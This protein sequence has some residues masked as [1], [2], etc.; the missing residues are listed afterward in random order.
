MCGINGVIY[1]NQKSNLSEINNMNNAIKHRGPDDDGLFA[2]E[3]I[4]L[5]HVRL[6]ILDL[7]K[8]GK[9]PMTYDNRFWISY[10]GEVY[11][12][13]EIRNNLIE[14]GYKFFSETDTEVILKSYIEWG[15][16]CFEKFNGMWALAILDIIKKKLIISRDR[17]GVKPCYY[18]LNKNKFIFS[19][20]IK[21]ILSSFSEI[22]LDKDKLLL[23]VR[24]LEKHFTTY[25]E[26]INILPPGNIL[27]IDITNLNISKLR[28]WRSI[29]NLSTIELNYNKSKEK[30]KSLLYEATKLRLVSDTKISTSL[31]GGIDSAVIFAILNSYSQKNNLSLDP[32][33]NK[34]NN[35]TFENAVELSKFYNRK[36]VI[37]N[38][39][40][41]DTEDFANLFASLEQPTNYFNQINIYKNQKENGFKISIDGHGADEC[42]G[43]YANNIL[44]FIFQHHNSLADAYKAY[45]SIKGEDNL[46]KLGKKYKF[47]SKV[48]KYNG[49]NYA[50]DYYKNISINQ[51]LLEFIEQNKKIEVPDFFLEDLNDLNELNYDQQSLLVDANY[52]NLQWLLNKWDRASMSNSVEIRSP[53]L[54]WNFFQYAISLPNSFKIKNGK[55]KSILRDAFSNILSPS[56]NNDFRKQGLIPI[57]MPFDHQYINHLEKILNQESFVKSNLWN[58]KK[59]KSKFETVKNNNDLESLRSLDLL[60]K[61][62]LMDIGFKNIKKNN[63]QNKTKIVNNYNFLNS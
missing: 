45:V 62:Y 60:S 8:K 17:Y 26:D 50:K 7:S 19:S 43:G 39:T 29:D 32:F 30:I 15:D 13:K 37:I 2:F 54:D 49:I 38:E 22:K 59:I 10:N 53:Y 31:S 21:G 28:W 58:G 23:S 3:N 36:P 14:K 33:I 4:A 46:I 35:I 51:N 25:Y 27:K 42:L 61:I 41:F 24:G 48:L 12:F 9:Q 16:K 44:S 55:N 11:N 6:S 34:N 5:G 52:G 57:D 40:K 47:A 63:Q 20:E 1:K 18:F 56:I